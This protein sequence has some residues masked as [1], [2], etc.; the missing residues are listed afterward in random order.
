MKKYIGI[1]LIVILSFSLGVYTR[2]KITTNDPIENEGNEVVEPTPNNDEKEVTLYFVNKE[3]VETGDESLEKLVEEKRV[4]KYSDI[5]LEEAIVRELMEG[6]ENKE[7][8]TL[9]PSTVK[10]LGVEVADKTAFVNFAREGL[11]GGSMQEDFTINQIVNSLIELDNIEKVQFLIDGEKSETLM[12]HFEILEP[13][14][15]EDYKQYKPLA[16]GLYCL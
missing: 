11:Y 14:Q 4:V 16:R 15:G 13:F 1:F 12:G 8:N 9:I 10:L 6:S 7:V 3:Y 5:S 2:S